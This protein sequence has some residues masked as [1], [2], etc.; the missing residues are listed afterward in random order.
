MRR[1]LVLTLSCVALAPA[2]S[3]ATHTVRIP[4]LLTHQVAT[5]HGKGIGPI[6]LPETMPADAA[7]LYPSVDVAGS[8][9][10][11]D[12]GSVKNCHASTAC[13]V[14]E[15][16][17]RH[18]KPSN[19]IKVHLTDGVTGY[20]RGLACGASCSAPSIE[21]RR[22][23]FVYHLSAE[24]GTERTAKAILTSMANSAIAHGAR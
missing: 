16:S 20:Y 21:F 8:G 18:G 2:A 3:A 17:A 23:G 9:Y 12:L 19:S 6:L 13:F 24:V 22:N 1:A 15:F 11:L 7:H 5:L 4:S 10:S 14:A